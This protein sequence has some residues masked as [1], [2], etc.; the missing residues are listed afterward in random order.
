MKFSLAKSGAGDLTTEQMLLTA[1]TG[2]YA[3]PFIAGFNHM[4]GQARAEANAIREAE[5]AAIKQGVRNQ[6][7]LVTQTFNKRKG[8]SGLGDGWG[9]TSPLGNQASQTGAVLN[10][11]TGVEFNSILG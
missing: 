8:A 5:K 7:A 9:D 1:A 3:L 2:G 11:T 6:N 4:Q 10:S